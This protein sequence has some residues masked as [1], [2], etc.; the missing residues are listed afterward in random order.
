MIPV[1]QFAKQTARIAETAAKL[2]ALDQAWVVLDEEF[3]LVANK[4]RQRHEAGLP[5]TPDLLRLAELAKSLVALE[6]A[7]I[8]AMAIAPPAL[9]EVRGG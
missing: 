9:R 7:A 3:A 4:V 5:A 8:E 2:K 1:E 6:Q